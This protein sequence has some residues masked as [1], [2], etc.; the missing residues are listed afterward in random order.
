MRKKSISRS[1]P[2]PPKPAFLQAAHPVADLHDIEE[3]R[4]NNDSPSSGE[5]EGPSRFWS[6]TMPAKKRG[7]SNVDSKKQQDGASDSSSVSGSNK[8][9]RSS[10]SNIFSNTI[11]DAFSNFTSNTLVGRQRQSQGTTDEEDEKL[12]QGDVEPTEEDGWRHEENEKNYSKDTPARKKMQ[13]DL[14]FSHHQPLTPGWESPWRPEAR[15]GN[16][17]EFGNYRYNHYGEGGYFPRSDTNRSSQRGKITTTKNGMTIVQARDKAKSSLLTIDW[18][19]RF[20]LDNAFVPLLFRAINIAFTTSVLAIAIR[21]RLILQEQGAEAAVGSSP[22]VAIIFSPLTL[23]HVGFQIWLEYFS[24][25]I[26]LWQVSSKL[27]Y[28]LID[29]SQS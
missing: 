16:S 29:V 3:R 28:T 24:R 19:K 12:E 25:P 17:I 14:S 27:F 13:Y 22:I 21:L 2:R 11:G 20:L 23:V 1:L 9:R 4:G 6:F 7:R 10:Y 8:G 18:W 26:G 5:A 15:V